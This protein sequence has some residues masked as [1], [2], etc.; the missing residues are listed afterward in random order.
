MLPNKEKE[1]IVRVKIF[2]KPLMRVFLHLVI[3]V[4][5]LASI[6]GILV[7][8]NS[9]SAYAKTDT[10]G[11]GNGPLL[12]PNNINSPNPNPL[13]WENG[14]NNKHASKDESEEESEE[15]ES[16]EEESE[17][18]PKEKKDKKVEESEEESEEEE[19][20]ESEEE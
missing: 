13:G 3:A 11:N 1:D 15:E 7:V 5:F 9:S 20:Q 2:V 8:W 6:S 14:K 4:I 17:E 19:S 16:E 18:E 12:A 10:A